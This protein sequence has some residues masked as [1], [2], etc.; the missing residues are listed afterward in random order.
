MTSFF[1][2]RVERTFSLLLFLVVG[3]DETVHVHDTLL[4]QTLAHGHRDT[5]VGLEFGSAN[6]SHGL[7]LVEAV[8]NA[9]STGEGFVVL[10]G[11]ISLVS[12][13]VSAESL[14]SNLLSDVELVGEGGGAGIKPVLGVWG[15][16][17]ETGSLNVLGPLSVL[18]IIKLEKALGKQIDKTRRFNL[19]HCLAEVIL[20]SGILNLLDFF[21]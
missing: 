5:F 10:S 7:E 3:G 20:T 17:F 21:R 13:I 9:L 6:K 16:L 1:C 12:S 14:N 2:Q 4:G 18:N 11:T 19:K 8:A 15:E